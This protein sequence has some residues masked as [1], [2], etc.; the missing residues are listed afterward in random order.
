VPDTVP[1][2]DAIDLLLAQHA[3]IEELF[4][5]VAGSDG[6]TRREAFEDLVRLLSVHETAEEELVH[7]LTRTL[8]DSDALVDDRLAEE[9]EAKE[10]LRTLVDGGV[11]AP[12]FDAGLLLLRKAVLTHA[13]YEERYEFPRLRAH[14]PA[15]RLRGLADAVR[16]AEAFA[17]TRPHPGT[18][19][20]AANLALGP[21][22]AVA[23][24]VRD[25]IRAATR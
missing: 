9:R 22:L 1:P 8:P 20:A 5:L 12:G 25:A 24:R 2:D 16:A 23:D 14:V 18:E 19:S 11:D 17:P 13:R 15:A 10:T 7:P 6:D 4:V 21:A 3:R